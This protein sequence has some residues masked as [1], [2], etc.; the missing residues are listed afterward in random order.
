MMQPTGFRLRDG[1][2]TGFEIS[3]QNASE[4]SAFDAV[5]RLVDA[6]WVGEGRRKVAVR[7]FRYDC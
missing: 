1:E 5:F 6:A 2:A 4:A 3:F 7:H